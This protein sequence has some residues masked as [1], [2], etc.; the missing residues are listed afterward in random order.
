MERYNIHIPAEWIPQLRAV[1]DKI[2]KQRPDKW[3]YRYITV[4]NLIRISISTMF[5][6]SGPDVLPYS[7]DARKAINRVCKFKPWPGKQYK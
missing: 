4:A 7:E 3:Y 1:R 5:S 2:V 6:L